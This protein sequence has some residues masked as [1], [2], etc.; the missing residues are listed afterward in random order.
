MV[1][2]KLLN[3]VQKF[4]PFFD[5]VLGVFITDQNFKDYLEVDLVKPGMEVLDME[6]DLDGLSITRQTKTNVYSIV[7]SDT[8]KQ[9]EYSW[10]ILVAN[11]DIRKWFYSVRLSKNNSIAL[12]TIRDTV[13]KSELTKL[14][15]NKVDELMLLDSGDIIRPR[16]MW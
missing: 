5:Q 7:L 2:W 6:F 15:D 13:V 10:C 14:D 11:K 4:D 16:Y 9:C 1:N 12:E 3:I 8:S